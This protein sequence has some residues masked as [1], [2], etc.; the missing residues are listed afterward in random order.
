MNAYLYLSYR[1]FSTLPPS[2]PKLYQRF[3]A[4]LV[5]PLRAVRIDRFVERASRV[6]QI[7]NRGKG[8]EVGRFAVDVFG[9]EEL[10]H[11]GA[12][13]GCRGILEEMDRTSVCPPSAFGAEVEARASVAGY[14]AYRLRSVGKLALG[15]CGDEND[16]AFTIASHG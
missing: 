10:T 3:T 8:E 4:R 13:C 6:P 14:F 1:Q 11:A 5:L 2:V 9:V 15:E 12:E 16:A 7:G